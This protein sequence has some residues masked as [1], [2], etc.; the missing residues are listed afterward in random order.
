MQAAESRLQATLGLEP[1]LPSVDAIDSRALAQKIALHNLI[2]Q[3][4]LAEQTGKEGKP[5]QNKEQPSK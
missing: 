1:N 3:S 5:Q 4:L 2:W